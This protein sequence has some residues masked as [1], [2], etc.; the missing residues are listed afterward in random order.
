MLSW[1]LDVLLALAGGARLGTAETLGLRLRL[2]VDSVAAIIVVVVVVMVAGGGGGGRALSSMASGMGWRRRDERDRG[3][4]GE[5]RRRGL[6][7]AG[8]G[9]H[10]ARCPRRLSRWG[11]QC[12]LAALCGTPLCTSGRRSGGFESAHCIRGPA[13]RHSASSEHRGPSTHY[14]S[15][16]R[17]LPAERL[18]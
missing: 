4:R 2:L 12:P 6:G 18:H 9:D 11:P 5:R 17:G 13:S 1:L 10:P 3:K 16:R 15:P 14:S 8:D 7:K